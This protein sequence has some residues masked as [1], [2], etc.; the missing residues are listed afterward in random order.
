MFWFFD[1]K[2]YGIL[3]SCSGLK[4]AAP[5]LEDEVLTLDCQGSSR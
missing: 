1:N 5:A 2:T 3:A 4:P